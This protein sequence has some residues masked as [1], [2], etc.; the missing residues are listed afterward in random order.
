MDTIVARRTLDTTP[1]APSLFAH[2]VLRSSSMAALTTAC[3]AGVGLALLPCIVGDRLGREP[4]SGLRGLQRLGQGRRRRRNRR[5]DLRLVR[6]AAVG[7]GRFGL[8]HRPRPRWAGFGRHVV[9]IEQVVVVDV[10]VVEGLQS[11]SRPAGFGVAHEVLRVV[12]GVITTSLVRLGVSGPPAP[13]GCPTIEH[14]AH[15]NRSPSQS[16]SADRG[17]GQS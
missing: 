6:P 13:G 2:F 12:F 9:V 7:V 10:I 4:A 3:E 5:A 1:V 8:G 11:A 14:H 15:S 16:R 17:R